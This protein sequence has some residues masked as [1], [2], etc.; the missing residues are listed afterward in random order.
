MS[1]HST[2][3]SKMFPSERR[4]GHNEQDE[5]SATMPLTYRA[6]AGHQRVLQLY[7]QRLQAAGVVTAQEVDE[8]QS[9]ALDMCVGHARTVRTWACTH[10]Y[11]VF[12]CIQRY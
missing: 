5:P 4:H 6:I 12:V 11:M 2:I 9:A 8:W 1:T 7:S 3:G 10:R